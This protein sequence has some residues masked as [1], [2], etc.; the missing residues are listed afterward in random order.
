MH[1]P[2]FSTLLVATVACEVDA[3]AVHSVASSV[4]AAAH[5]ASGGTIAP[6]MQGMSDDAALAKTVDSQLVNAAGQQITNVD[7]QF[8]V[9]STKQ[10]RPRRL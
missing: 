9:C 7:L 6:M 10:T 1:R 2:A 8:Q 4:T 5:R 3:V